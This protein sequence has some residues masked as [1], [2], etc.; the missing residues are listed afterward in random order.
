MLPQDAPKRR[1]QDEY[2]LEYDRGRTKK[3][4]TKK[5]GGEE[6]A[7]A[8]V[9]SR[10]FDAA[11]QQQQLEGVQTE[12]RGNRKRRSQGFQQH[13]QRLQHKQ[14]RYSGGGRPSFGGR[15]GGKRGRG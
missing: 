1:R 6:G 7:A 8:G 14:R 15:S 11:W 10:D 2:D 12:L 3:V 5:G 4:R 9:G 13:K